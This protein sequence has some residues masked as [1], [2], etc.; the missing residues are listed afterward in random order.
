VPSTLVVGAQDR[1]FGP[2]GRAYFT[3]AKEAGDAKVRLVEA[4][5]S[6]HFELIAPKTTTWPLVLAEFKAMFEKI[7]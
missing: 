5:E 6:G 1:G 7:R 4:P 3:R 2:N